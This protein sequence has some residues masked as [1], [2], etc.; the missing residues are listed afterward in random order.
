LSDPEFDFIDPE[1]DLN[2][3]KNR[4]KCYKLLNFDYYRFVKLKLSVF[5]GMVP[6]CNK[7]LLKYH[8]SQSDHY[9]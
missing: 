8:T 7:K 1:L 5:K 2:H 4:Q 6:V 3:Y 9:S